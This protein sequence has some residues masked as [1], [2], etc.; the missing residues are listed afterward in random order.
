MKIPDRVSLRAITD[1][2]DK[3]F[4][5]SYNGRVRAERGYC[6]CSTCLHERVNLYYEGLERAE[7]LE[8]ENAHAIR[9]YCDKHSRFFHQF[10][11]CP[12][13]SNNCT[14]HQASVPYFSIGLQ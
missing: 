4:S 6:E 11:K 12:E 3:R 9:N 13:C 2:L 14:I 8:C 7:Q 5:V 10:D 1:E